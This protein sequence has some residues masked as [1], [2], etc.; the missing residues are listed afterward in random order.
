MDLQLQDKLVQAC[1]LEY[2][3]LAEKQAKRSTL[4]TF[5][6]GC[7]IFDYK[8]DIVVGK[9]CSHHKEGIKT[10]TFHAET[11]ALDESYGLRKAVD[12]PYRWT[13]LAAIIVTL[14][15]K[16]WAYSSRPCASCATRML[17]AVSIVHYAERLNDGTWEVN[18]ESPTHLI[19]RG[20][21]SV[22]L[23]SYAREQRIV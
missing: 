1:P 2:W 11:H 3:K 13:N 16:N 15:R 9:G 20:Y 8:N 5:K 7:V 17:G 10:P 4:A 12:N 6:T 14:G 22:N 23:Q 18:S 19:R 21:D